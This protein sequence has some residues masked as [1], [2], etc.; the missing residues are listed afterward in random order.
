MPVWEIVSLGIVENENS[1]ISY[2]ASRLSKPVRPL[3]SSETQIKIF[4][5]NP[6]AFWP[7]IVTST[8]NISILPAHIVARPE[9]GKL[10]FSVGL[11]E[12]A[13]T[14]FANRCCFWS[15]KNSCFPGNTVHNHSRLASRKQRFGKM[16]HWVKLFRS[17]WANKAKINAYYKKMKVF[18]DLACM[19]TGCWGLPNQNM[20]LS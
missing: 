2:S 10:D 12:K 6:R 8:W 11:N 13:N 19:S 9:L 15:T 4:W 5:W 3:L 7:S 17:R 14:F 18:F 1:I 16:H 20:N